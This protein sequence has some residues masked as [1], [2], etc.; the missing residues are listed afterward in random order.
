[1]SPEYLIADLD[2][3]KTNFSNSG[4]GI[5]SIIF[6]LTGFL[7]LFVLV[8]ASYVIQAINFEIKRSFHSDALNYL[9]EMPLSIFF[10]AAIGLLIYGIYKMFVERRTKK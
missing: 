8:L 7:T 10:Y 1:M 5:A 2:I 3:A 6:L 9:Y 4:R